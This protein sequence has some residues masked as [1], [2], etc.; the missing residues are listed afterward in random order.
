MRRSLE[1]VVVGGGLG[2]L[3]AATW[4]ARGGAKVRVLERARAVGGRARSQ[5]EAG[6]TLNLGPHALY[7][8]GAAFAALHELGVPV[9]GRVVPGAARCEVEGALRTLPTS[10]WG[11][12]TA[13]FWTP[14]ERWQAARFFAS[15]LAG[16]GPSPGTSVAEWVDGLDERVRRW[17]LTVV[18]TATYSHAPE[19]ADAARVRAQ[20]RRAAKG[21]LY[22]DGGWQSLVDGVRGTAV[23]AGVE[24]VE[25]VSVSALGPGHVGLDGGGAHTGDVVVVATPPASARALGLLPELPTPVRVSCLDLG[26][27]RLPRPE[28][29]AVFGLDQPVYLSEHNR[30]AALAPPGGA[31][32]HVARYLHPE[33]PPSA[34]G[35]ATL[36]ADLDRLQPG[37]RDEVVVRRGA[38][39]LLVAGA[40]DRFDQPRPGLRSGFA[41]LVGDWVDS[42]Y[43]LADAAFDSARRV[44][45]AVLAEGLVGARMAE[46]AA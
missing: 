15:A 34:G 41:W 45:A 37:W 4:L 28:N 14:S 35:F 5:V 8:A 11:V 13:P 32:L 10:A 29:A 43:M 21:V 22:L 6:F 40:L 19:L 46:R 9:A 44:A 27:R 16:P 7:R 18:R 23:A 36:E 26:L 38:L 25:G 42:P 20:L 39:G 33:E 30:V 17:V 1:V 2:G 24:V 12:A 3:A 31:L